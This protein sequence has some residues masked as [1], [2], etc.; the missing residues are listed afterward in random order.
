MPAGFL[1]FHTNRIRRSDPANP[2]EKPIRPVFKASTNRSWGFDTLT[3]YHSSRDSRRE[4]QPS[5]VVVALQVPVR[6]R[7]VTPAPRKGVGAASTPAVGSIPTSELAWEGYLLPQ[8]ERRRGFSAARGFTAGCARGWPLPSR[9]YTTRCASCAAART[10]A[11][12][13][14]PLMASAWRSSLCSIHARIRQ[15]WSTPPR[16]FAGS[17]SRT[18]AL[19]T[20]G[21]NRLRARSTCLTS[22]SR[23]PSEMRT[24]PVTS[25]L[26]VPRTSDDAPF[27]AVTSLGCR[28]G[29]VQYFFGTPS[30]GPVRCIVWPWRP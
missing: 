28:P 1:T 6:I 18:V 23:S 22:L 19:R 5:R 9:A 21:P 2:R 3:G 27:P 4:G 17:L 16:G 11:S 14:P 20:C 15:N 7:A 8:R 29:P 24:S 10:T 26:N 13:K 30:I 12:S 25:T